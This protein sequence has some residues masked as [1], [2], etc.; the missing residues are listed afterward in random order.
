QYATCGCSPLGKVSKVSEAYAP[1]AAVVW[2]H[3]YTFDGLGR[4]TRDLLPDGSA[5]VY[6]YSGNTTTVTP[7][8]N[9]PSNPVSP[10]KSYATD[11]Q[12]NMTLVSEPDPTLGL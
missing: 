10:W 12:G 8:S 2:A 5:T 11:G 4:M 9:N 7:P 6:A 1:N 3:Q